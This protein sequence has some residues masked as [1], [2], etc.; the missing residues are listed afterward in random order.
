MGDHD[1]MRLEYKW[2]QSVIAAQSALAQRGPNNIQ[3]ELISR[4][5]ESFHSIAFYRDQV[6]ECDN[7]NWMIW[8]HYS[9]SPGA[10]PLIND[11]HWFITRNNHIHSP[12]IEINYIFTVWGDI[13]IIIWCLG[14][15]ARIS[16]V[17]DVSRTATNCLLSPPFTERPQTLNPIWSVSANLLPKELYNL[18]SRFNGCPCLN[19]CHK[20]SQDVKIS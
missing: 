7:L 2:E 11:G 16:W 19:S 15:S 13:I 3:P 17:S 12:A 4:A 8:L 14:A 20:L 1:H 9:S 6:S 18:N 10:K 5:L